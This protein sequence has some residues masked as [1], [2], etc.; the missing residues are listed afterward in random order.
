MFV[1][2]SAQLRHAIPQS[3]RE[4]VREYPHGFL[5]AFA[6][7]E[8]ASCITGASRGRPLAPCYGMT[9]ETETAWW[10]QIMQL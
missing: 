4:K 5:S 9:E 6:A 10:S 8:T 1:P 3:G 7:T 2:T